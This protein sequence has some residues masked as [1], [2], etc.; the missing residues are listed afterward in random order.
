MGVDEFRAWAARE[1]LEPLTN[2]DWIGG[3]I[4]AVVA[5]CLGGGRYVAEDFMR[6]DPRKWRRR[7]A[8]RLTPAQIKARMGRCVTRNVR[9]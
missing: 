9:A 3:R 5:S 2:H 7:M 6:V 1:E 8:P 4:S